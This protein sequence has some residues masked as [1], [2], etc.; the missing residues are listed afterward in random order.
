M[1]CKFS[2]DVKVFN[3]HQQQRHIIMITFNKHNVRRVNRFINLTLHMISHLLR[4]PH[5]AYY[6]AALSHNFSLSFAGKDVEC[7]Q[8]S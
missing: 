6:C 5:S 4:L 7:F 8:L 1:I 3:V 2:N